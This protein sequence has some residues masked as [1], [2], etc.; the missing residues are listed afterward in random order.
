MSL[1]D[2]AEAVVS[3]ERRLHSIGYLSHLERGVSS[4]PFFTYVAIAGALD[5]HP[6]RIFGPDP[7]G[8]DPDGAERMLI[9]CLRRAGIKPE[10]AMLRLLGD[11]LDADRQLEALNG[12][13]FPTGGR[14]VVGD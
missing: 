12:N 10:E 9:H 7:V 3:A 13:G 14:P 6:G 8:P 11:S 1:R 2:L 4:A 5:E